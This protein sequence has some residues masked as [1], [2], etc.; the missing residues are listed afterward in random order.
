MVDSGCWEWLG[1]HNGKGYGI[2]WYEN[3]YRAAHRFGYAMMRS[4]IPD[5]LQLDHLC[6]NRGCVNP[7]HLEPVTALENQM[8]GLPHRATPSMCPKGH[9]YSPE[10]TYVPPSKPHLR[11]CRTCRRIAGKEANRKKRIARGEPAEGRDPNTCKNGHVGQRGSNGACRACQ[12]DA[13]RRWK[14]RR[15]AG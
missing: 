7:W 12:R 8:R 4:P 13:T 3:S 1:S 14:E 2:F 5:G 9:L 10:N 11:M 15:A 6:R